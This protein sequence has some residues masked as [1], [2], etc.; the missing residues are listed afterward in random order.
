MKSFKSF[1]DLQKEV[2][3]IGYHKKVEDVAFKHN[4][5][6]FKQMSKS[7]E[8]SIF[9]LK[10]PE[11]A[12]AAYGEKEFE[13]YQRIALSH[14]NMHLCNGKVKA[15]VYARDLQLEMDGEEISEGIKLLQQTVFSFVVP[16]LIFA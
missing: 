2:D 10:H 9:C 8:I 1:D 16:K 13:R 5:D 15:V 11:T 7:F 4:R 6:I 12:R 14:I 3:P